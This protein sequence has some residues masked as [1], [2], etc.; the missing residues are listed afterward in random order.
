MTGWPGKTRTISRGPLVVSVPV[1]NH[2][3]ERPTSP[4]LHPL[5]PP[6][7]WLEPV[8]LTGRHVI[9]EAIGLHHAEA[10]FHALDHPEV[11]RHQVGRRPS[12]PEDTAAAIASELRDAALGQ[13][14][15]WVYLSPVSGEVI[16]MTSYRPPIEKYR[17]VHIGSTLTS[18]AHWRTGVNTEAKLMLMSRAFDTLGAVR[19]ELQTDILNLRSQ[20][21]IERLGCTREGVL[22]KHKPRP[23]GTWR[24]SVFYG[25]LDTEWPAVRERLAARLAAGI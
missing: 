18:H 9:L 25:L 21:A 17:S 20:A 1:I 2:D 24:D 19:V 7:P 22:R 23:D 15:P 14:V 3:R 11:W 8:T 16:G 4:A 10:L 5:V 12:S 13:C 6:S